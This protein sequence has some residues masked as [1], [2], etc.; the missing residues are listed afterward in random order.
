MTQAQRRDP[1]VGDRRAA[2]EHARLELLAA[3][4]WNAASRWVED[5]AG[6]VTYVMEGGDGDV[7]KILVHGGLS[8]GSEWWPLAGRLSGRVVIPDRPGCGLSYIPEPRRSTFRLEA[9]RWLSDLTDSLEAPLV[10]LVGNSLGGYF[11]LVFALAHPDRVRNLVLVGAPAGIHRR[12]PR[13]VRLWGNPLTGRLITRHPITHPEKMRDVFQDL[14]VTD[15][16]RIPPDALEVAVAGALLPGVGLH[17][18]RML[19]QVLDIG[20]VRKSLLIESEVARLDV[21]TRFVWGEEDAFLSPDEADRIWERMPRAEIRRI[22][23][24][25]H[26][27]QL[28]QPDE[29]AD[30][31]VS[32]LKLRDRSHR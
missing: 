17:A 15:A 5:T 26:L 8:E 20:G 30:A 21:P 13:F 16:K 28:D 24:A 14:L 4:G 23:D 22:S 9:V 3:H 27:P 12:V 6:R 31:V 32:F 11:S 10:D 2:F 18:F 19:R 25:G 29:V 7:P 1:S